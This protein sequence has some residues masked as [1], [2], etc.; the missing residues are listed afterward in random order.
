M[1]KTIISYLVV[2][3]DEGRELVQVKLVQSV[4]EILLG[5]FSDPNQGRQ[6]QSSSLARFAV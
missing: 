5:I 4:D 1:K 2:I 3:R 6:Y